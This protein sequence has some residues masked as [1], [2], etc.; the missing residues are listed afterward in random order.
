[1]A[2]LDM[3]PNNVKDNNLKHSTRAAVVKMLMQQAYEL[4][5]DNPIEKE[6]T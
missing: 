1:M 5:E 4:K 6:P 2:I 3:I